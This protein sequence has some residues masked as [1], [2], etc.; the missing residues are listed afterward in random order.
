[1]KANEA[2]PCTGNAASLLRCAVASEYTG[3]DAEAARL[4]SEAAEQMLEGQLA[5]YHAHRLRLMLA[6]SDVVGLE[7]LVG[8]IDLAAVPDSPYRFDQPPAILDALVALGDHKAIEQMAPRWLRPGTY[9][10]PFAL[11]ALGVARGDAE[12]LDEASRRF[13]AI[14][15][16]WRADETERWRVAR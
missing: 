15:L 12:L 4:E 1:M 7:R 16:G 10:E 3:D 6:R 5:Y 14:G 11:R 8:S 13:E 9:A 2:A